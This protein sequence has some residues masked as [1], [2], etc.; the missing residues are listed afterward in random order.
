MTPDAYRRYLLSPMMITAGVA[1]LARDFSDDA[2]APLTHWH[3]L[4]R[5]ATDAVEAH[6]LPLPPAPRLR[7]TCR[8]PDV[9]PDLTI[10]ALGSPNRGRHEIGRATYH[11][12]TGRSSDGRATFHGRLW[13]PHDQEQA[14]RQWW[15]TRRRIRDAH[16]AEINAAQRAYRIAIAERIPSI[17][18]IESSTGRRL[19]F[20]ERFP[21]AWL[22]SRPPRFQYVLAARQWWCLDDW[23]DG[24]HNTMS[25]A[26]FADHYRPA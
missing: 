18:G 21:D 13:S 22:T 26:A 16:Q 25:A 5:R 7:W 8:P 3:A 11:R 17:P 4:F 10:E 14:L 6:P 2:I 24:F 9:S 15:E 23:I 20:V 1:A 19:R 12:T